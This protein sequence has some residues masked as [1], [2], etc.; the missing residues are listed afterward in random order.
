[1][2]S[3]FFSES[4]LVNKSPFCPINHVVTRLS[5]KAPGAHLLCFLTPGFRR[6]AIGGWFVLVSL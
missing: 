3:R 4:S 1:M 2:A 6:A 5:G